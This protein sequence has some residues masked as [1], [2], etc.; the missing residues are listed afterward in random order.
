MS[1]A[2]SIK[3][4]IFKR[5][6][7][8]PA[9]AEAPRGAVLDNPYLTARRTWNDHV[10]SLVT[11]RQ[12]WQVV[13]ILSMMVALAGVGGI[14]HIGSQSK[15]VPYVVEVDKLGQSMAVTPAQV[16][17][18]VDLRV[19]KSQVASFVADARTVTPDVALQ[20]KSIFRLYALLAPNDPA[21][22]KMNEWLNGTK[23]SSPFVRAAEETVSVD[24]RSVMQQ[25]PETWQVDWEESTRDRQGLLKSKAT[26]RALVTTY[27]AEPTTQTSEEQVRMNPIGTFVRDFSWSKQL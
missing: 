7:S 22:Q 2:D 20:R 9:K 24:I 18:P 1:F 21:T 27:V 10:G 8:A 12:S 23:E 13:G 25:T 19:L 14:I 11:S 15:F 4:L 17:A 6:D 16:A 5:P 26:W 3:G